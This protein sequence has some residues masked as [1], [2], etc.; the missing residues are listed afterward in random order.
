MQSPVLQQLEPVKNQRRT[1]ENSKMRRKPATESLA[2]GGSEQ[3]LLREKSRKARR[4]IG[5]GNVKSLVTLTRSIS[6]E[7]EV[8]WDM[9]GEN[10][11]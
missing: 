7:M 9:R 10:R 4:I 5:F 2:P 6:V 3:M 1:R 11:L 8:H